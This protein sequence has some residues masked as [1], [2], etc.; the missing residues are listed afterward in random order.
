MLKILIDVFFNLIVIFF[1]VLNMTILHINIAP[2]KDSTYRELFDN[3]FV[4]IMTILG[5]IFLIIFN[6]HFDFI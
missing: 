6:K 4:V 5:L 2:S 1:L 3:I